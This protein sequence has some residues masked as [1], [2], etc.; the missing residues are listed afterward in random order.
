MQCLATVRTLQRLV[1]TSEEVKLLWE[2]AN[3]RGGS[4]RDHFD[5]AGS[6]TKHHIC[7]RSGMIIPQKRPRAAHH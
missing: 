3:G 1:V 2:G 5:I 7:S 4:D 6:I